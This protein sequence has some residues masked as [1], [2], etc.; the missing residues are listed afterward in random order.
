M[1]IRLGLCHELVAHFDR[2]MAIDGC[3]GLSD[4]HPPPS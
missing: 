1:A 3:I 2:F 4:V